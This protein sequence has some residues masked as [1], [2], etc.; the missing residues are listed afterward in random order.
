MNHFAYAPVPKTKDTDVQMYTQPTLAASLLSRTANANAAVLSKLKPNT[1][2]PESAR[3]PSASANNLHT[4]AKYGADHPS[5]AHDIFTYLLKELTTA[6]KEHRPPVLFTVD[7]LN[8][9]MGPSKYKSAEFETVHSHQLTMIHTYLDLLFSAK[10]PLANGGLILAATSGSNVPTN[11]S[12]DLLLKQV[13]AAQQGKQPTDKNFPLPNPY[14]KVDSRPLN[15]LDPAAG[16][17][18]MPLQGVSK[19]EAAQLMQYYVLSGVLKESVTPESISEKWTLSGG[20]NVGEICRWGEKARLD[21]EKL[22]TK[23]GT[24]EG[25]KIGQ[26]EHRPRG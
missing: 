8:H 3:V 13:K 18:L 14:Q 23:F 24:N 11:P 22:V 7:N 1:P 26:G 25:I 16:T 2:P 17:Q 5:A 6:G 21:P 10:K 15:L 20:G 9:W 19:A 4:I 12:F